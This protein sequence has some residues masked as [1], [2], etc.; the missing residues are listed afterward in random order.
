MTEDVQGISGEYLKQYIERIERLEEEKAGIASPANGELTAMEKNTQ[1]NIDLGRLADLSVAINNL[2]SY[3]IDTKSGIF[4]L[5]DSIKS[6]SGELYHMTLRETPQIV[7][8]LSQVINQLKALQ[9]KGFPVLR[10][11]YA[12]ILSKILWEDDIYVSASGHKNEILNLT[13]DIFVTNKNIKK[14]QDVLNEVGDSPVI[15]L[16]FKK[17]TYSWYKGQPDKTVFDIPSFADSLLQKEL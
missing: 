1:Q 10:E 9:I 17:V 11:N 14:Y 2:S 6:I 7:D 8:S 13:G 16:R 15:T 12:N 4:T 3:K 5:A